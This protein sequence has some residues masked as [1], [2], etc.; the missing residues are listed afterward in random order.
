MN[1]PKFWAQG[2]SGAF[3]AWRWSNISVED[4][5]TAAKLAAEKLAAQFD[6]EDDR[7][8]DRYGYPDRPLREPVL[9][10]FRNTAGELSAVVTRNSYGCQVLNAAQALFVDIDFPPPPKTGGLFSSLFGKKPEPPPD[11]AAPAIAK[12]QEWANRHPGWNWRIY[13]TAAGLRLLATHALF[14]PTDRSCHDV[15]EAMGSDRLYRKLCETQQCF[16]ARL[17][18]K[19]WRCD[20][21]H[22]P[23]R[24]PHPDPSKE[25]AVARWDA[26]YQAASHLWATCKLLSEGNGQ[27]H[28][29]L[30]PLVKLHD[31]MTRATSSL[32]LA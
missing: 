30:Q 18:P 12:A 3:S 26:K 10:E 28:S 6:L 29:D 20:V 14:N 22:P 27:I 1:F 13:R 19:P 11:P 21:A 16:R 8:P 2:R 31:E 25:L 9:Q 17:T 4:A 32:P 23:F 5:Q 24:W 7:K 15:F